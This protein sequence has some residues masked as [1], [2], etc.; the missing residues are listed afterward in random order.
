VNDKKF[1]DA[2]M[3]AFLENAALTTLPSAPSMLDLAA[4]A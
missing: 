4:I 3:E 2:V 1:T